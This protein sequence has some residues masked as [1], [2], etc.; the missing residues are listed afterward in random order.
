MSALETSW[1]ERRVVPR[2]VEVA[3]GSGQIKKLRAQT[4][5]GLSGR[6]LEIGFG[7]GLNLPFLPADVTSLDAVEPSEVG[8]ERSVAARTDTA[9]RIDRIGLDGRDL[10]ADDDSYD[11]VLCTFSLC[12]IP[13]PTLAVAELR[14]VLRPGGAFHVLEHGLSPDAG[15]ARWQH[16]LDPIERRV[17]GGCHLTR[18]PL[19][20]LCAGGFTVRESEQRYLPG[21]RIGRPWAYCYRA[22]GLPED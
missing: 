20:L 13:D 16:R 15:V 1:W 12:T 17:A 6:V 21:P 8:W 5:A 22:I 19:A 2:L 14:R 10:A 4:C 18:D 9:L 7:S 11:A 3:L